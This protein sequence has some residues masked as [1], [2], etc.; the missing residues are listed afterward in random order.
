MRCRLA[1]QAQA[2]A[3]AELAACPPRAPGRTALLLRGRG[4]RLL[5]LQRRVRTQL[6]MAQQHIMNM[7]V[8]RRP[9]PASHSARLPPARP[10]SSRSAVA[11][12]EIQS[13]R[14]QIRHSP[15]TYAR[16]TTEGLLLVAISDTLLGAVVGSCCVH[17]SFH[18]Q[19]RGTHLSPR[20]RLA[21][22]ARA[23]PG[24]R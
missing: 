4:L 12:V 18:K 13:R 14:R 15:G 5:N 21:A 8:R 2:E 6:E 11:C 24:A 19:S 23:A 1:A 9:R 3:E 20:E 10:P 7:P 22:A 17:R 16:I